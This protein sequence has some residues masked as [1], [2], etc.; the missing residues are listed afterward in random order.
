MSGV[1]EPKWRPHNLAVED[2]RERDEYQVRAGGVSPHHVRVLARAMDCEG[3]LE[4]IKVAKIGRAHWVVD[5][6]HRLAAARKLGW[7]HI[8]AS[9][10]TMSAGEAQGYSLLSNTK[11]GKGL[12]R[13]DKTR[14]FEQYV[15]QGKHVGADGV[16]KA[17]RVIQGELNHIYSHETIRTKLKAL[18]VEVDL[19]VEYP[20]GY[21]PYGGGGDDEADLALELA[22]GAQRH[23]EAFGSL[24][25]DLEDYAQREMLK[26]ARELVGRLERGERVGP[27]DDEAAE[28]LLDI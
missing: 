2:V 25:F 13:H 5:G 6:F 15:E 9:V 28:A 11:H 7:S 10:A 19:E 12:S 21:K 14:L 8:A 18:G 16:V 23:L 3:D 22:E 27:V 1:R 20:G 17:S 4:P 24:F 26:A